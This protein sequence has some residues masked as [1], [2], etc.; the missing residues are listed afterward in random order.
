MELAVG[1]V[2]E[3]EELGVVPAAVVVEVERKWVMEQNIITDLVVMD[4]FQEL[5]VIFLS[6]MDMG[7]EDRPAE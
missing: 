1:A 4:G 7:E 6:R 3:M 2:E 5:Q